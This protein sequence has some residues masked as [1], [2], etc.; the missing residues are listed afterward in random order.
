MSKYFI[1]HSRSIIHRTAFITDECNHQ[2]IIHKQ[3]EETNEDKKI[4]HLLNQ[5]GYN[6]CPYC[7]DY[8]HS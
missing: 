5:N 8:F 6:K 3:L 4:N 7:L 1:D 2:A